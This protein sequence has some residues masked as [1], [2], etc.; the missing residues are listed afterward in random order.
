MKI[1]K[2]LPWFCISITILLLVSCNYNYY[3]GSQLE[4][5]KRYEEANIQYHRAYT[6][7]PGNEDYK[8]AFLRTSEKTTQEL[9][10]RYRKYLEEKKYKMAFNRLEQARSLSSENAEIKIEIKKWYRVLLAGKVDF[11]FKSLANQI[12]L[13]DKM[14]LEIRFNT[15]EASQ[16]LTANIDNQ[17]KIFNIEDV[18]Y[19]PPPSLFLFYSINSIGV[20]FSNQN[21][22]AGQFRQSRSSGSFKKFIDFKTPVLSDINGKLKL[23]NNQ[24]R[25]VENFYPFDYLVKANSTQPWMPNRH[26]KF[27][28]T[29]DDNLIKVDSSNKEIGYLPQI[30]YFNLANQRIFLDF[31]HIEVNQRKIGGLWSIKRIIKEERKYL[32]D[33]QKNI[34]LNPYFYYF[35]GGF[36]V[37]ISKS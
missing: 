37:V 22:Y 4:E 29:L 34:I 35:E 2:L 28:V 17:N 12:H 31:G 1:A 8:Q 11:K 10:K 19:D 20:H 36:P 7:S 18:L 9:M 5:K 14:K 25:P 26:I 6:S 33:L 15:P 16:R 27:S 23:E 21:N 13:S 3:R 30:I 32:S 24:P